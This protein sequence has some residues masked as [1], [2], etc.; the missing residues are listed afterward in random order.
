V[1]ETDHSWLSDLRSYGV[2]VSRPVLEDR[3][4]AGAPVVEPHR[5]EALREAY[6]AFEAGS[7]CLA[8]WIGEIARQLMG[9]ENHPL[10]IFGESVSK[11][12]SL[13]EGQKTLERPNGLILSP[14]GTTLVPRLGIWLVEKGGKWGRT[15]ANAQRFL[16]ETHDRNFSL[17]LVTDGELLRLYHGDV[18][19]ESWVEWNATR[20]FD[21][22]ARGEEMA[23]FALI[24]SKDMLGIGQERCPLEDLVKESKKKQGDLSSRLGERLRIAVE[25][26]INKVVNS[27]V[28]RCRARGDGSDPIVMIRTNPD[29][30][31]LP[32]DLALQFL[33]QAAIRVVMRLVFLSYAESRELLPMGERNYLFGYSLQRLYEQLKKN[34][35]TFGEDYLRGQLWAWPRLLALFDLIR[36]GSRHNDL[37]LPAYGGELFARGDATSPVRR[38]LTLFE[39]PVAMTDFDVYHLLELVRRSGVSKNGQIAAG[40]DAV[41]FSDLR[42]EYIGIMYEGFLDY[43]PRLVHEEDGAYVELNG[44]GFH[45]YPLSRLEGMNDAQLRDFIKKVREGF[46]DKIVDE[47]EEDEDESRDE[48]LEGVD[49]SP[50]LVEPVILSGELSTRTRDWAKKA[51]KACR[52]VGKRCTLADEEKAIKSL[53]Q[54]EHQPGKVFLIS[55]TGMRKG[56]GTYYTR[57]GLAIPLVQRT[58]DPLVLKNL[59]TKE[60]KT[61]QEILELKVVDPAMGSGSFLVAASNFLAEALYRSWKYHGFIDRLAG[62]ERLLFP[63]GRVSTGLEEEDLV[64]RMPDEDGF[65]D[66]FLN[67]LRRH[68]IE[69][70]IYGVDINPLAVELAK[71]SLWIE[72]LDSSLPFEFLD[73]KLKVGNS[74]VGAWLFEAFEYPIAAWG[75]WENVAKSK[76]PLK[77]VLTEPYAWIREGEAACK[78]ELKSMVSGLS[79]KPL[80]GVSVPQLTKSIRER[81]E[82]IH[83]ASEGDRPRRYREFTESAEY[84]QLKAYLDRWC[85]LW[86]WLPP[87]DSDDDALPTPSWF[88]RT[89]A[90]APGRLNEI[91]RELSDVQRFF[92]WQIEFPDAFERDDS[93]FDAVV[94]NPPWNR[95]KPESVPFFSRY[96]PLFPTYGKQKAIE[97]ERRLFNVSPE[98]AIEWQRSYLDIKNLTYLAKNIQLPFVASIGKGNNAW[99]ERILK[100]SQGARE[101]YS[102][103]TNKIHR[104]FAI[105]G[106]GDVNLYKM[107]TEQGAFLLRQGG[108]MGMV[109]PGAVYSDYGAL[110]IRKAFL[111]DLGWEWLF[112][113]ENRLGI[114]PVHSSYIFCC[115]V[116]QAGKASDQLRAAFMVHE[117]SDWSDTEFPCMLMNKGLIERFSPLALIPPSVSGPK[118]LQVL[119]KMYAQGSIIGDPKRGHGLRYSQEFDMTNDSHLFPVREKWEQKGFIRDPFGLWLDKSGE[120]GLPL[121]EGKAIKLFDP[122]YAEHISGNIWR[123]MPH[124]RKVAKTR[125]IMSR[126]DY[127]ESNKALRGAKYAFRDISRGTDERTMVGAMVWDFPQGRNLGGYCLAESPTRPDLELC[128]M[129]G[130]PFDYILRQRKMGMHNSRYVLDEIPLSGCGKD[131][132]YLE[133]SMRLGLSHPLFSAEWLLLRDRFPSPW[134]QNWLW[135]AE[136]RLTVSLR[137]DAVALMH[138]GL[139]IEDAQNVLSLDESNGRGFFRTDNDL[140]GEDARFRYAGLLLML[141]RECMEDEEG[142]VLARWSVPPEALAARDAARGPEWRGWEPGERLSPAADLEAYQNGGV[143]WVNFSG[144]TP[145]VLDRPLESPRYALHVHRDTLYQFICRSRS[146]GFK[147]EVLEP[148][149]ALWDAVWRNDPEKSVLTWSDCDAYARCVLSFVRPEGAYNRLQE[150][151]A[152]KK[153]YRYIYDPEYEAKLAPEEN[154]L[155]D[156]PPSKK[157]F[158]LEAYME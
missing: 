27:A 87:Q 85:A 18:E 70:C 98:I 137:C 67:R 35:D 17:G 50:D 139:S 156:Q 53:V 2:L 144:G 20:W 133:G 125:Y 92:H 88:Y 79:I 122:F 42:T 115:I 107:F 29:G 123:P 21:E 34:H 158:T 130:L 51:A 62:G 72:T 74:L 48:D 5:E 119:E 126:S 143:S 150:V 106:G 6:R 63:D 52:M 129:N 131:P 105:Q 95:V 55:W 60:P 75:R 104:P 7:T 124:Y 118:D 91:V 149:E 127:C 3:F 120:V 68:V 10:V 30:T 114:F 65:E 138:A 136:R 69:R 15:C 135:S 116:L 111:N 16:R 39:D 151:L 12:I 101:W 140:T 103:D 56:S 54:A 112:S 32:E 157:V 108:R 26:M 134:S 76:D 128:E 99:S 96:D 110:E 90:D 153:P 152:E 19:G 23:A 47:E 102:N 148:Y 36:D 25:E 40:G 145:R 57:P 84:R 22:A 4:P 43:F 142:S 14:Q 61:P 1:I 86:F 33:Y 141:Y 80:F 38:A 58:L 121:M 24:L 8:D 9:I 89:P 83:L 113:F 37:R 73:H 66:Y 44:K 13:V 93:G 81:F 94:G 155:K 154:V 147:D 46:K 82:S 100:T 109:L 64:T 71:L 97:E 31:V 59:E 77:Q 132:A 78:E 45:A 11:H 117:L 49:T 28:D 146:L 41:D